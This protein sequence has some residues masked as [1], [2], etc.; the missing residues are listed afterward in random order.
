MDQSLG[1]VVNSQP[2]NVNSN[3]LFNPSTL[4]DPREFVRLWVIINELQIDSIDG[5]QENGKRTR[6]SSVESK[7]VLDYNQIVTTLNQSSKTK[8]QPIK[9]DLL[10]RAF[11]ELILKQR[12]QIVLNTIENLKYDS[13]LG[14]EN[15]NIFVKAITGGA[16]AV[17]VA[18]VKHFIWQV[19]RKLNNLEVTNHLM[20]ILV[21]NQRSGKSTAAKKLTEPLSGLVA[22]LSIP[23][24][25][26]DRYAWALEEQYIVLCDE[27]S[28]MV[29]ADLEKVKYVLTAQTITSRP[30][31]TTN[32]DKIP[33]N[34]TF[35]GTSNKQLH[36]I[37]RD[38]TGLGRFFPIQTIPII[39][40]EVI[41]KINYTAIWQSVDENKSE[42]YLKDVMTELRSIQEQH[43]P[44]GAVE[45]FIEHYALL[46]DLNKQVVRSSELYKLFQSFCE[47]NGMKEI[48][49]SSFGKKLK[50]NGV[51]SERISPQ[52][53][54][55]CTVYY[56]SDDVVLP[57]FINQVATN[58]K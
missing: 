55:K 29:R 49:S 58:K 21:G 44:K 7:M 54:K 20:P 43:T 12:Q 24:I 27:M 1:V 42:G 53:E 50:A 30:L 5:F 13:A 16:Q 3:P 9:D 6:R 23:Q 48:D 57:S 40:W 36:E 39:D 41:N 25:T 28:G 14:S 2:Q 45:Q 35:L 15:I 33:N 56:I 47:E 11:A 46:G 8:I 4:I 22:N 32:Y 37:I 51:R 17:E 31:H 38:E 19:K 34:C 52:N 18:V 10:K 26:D